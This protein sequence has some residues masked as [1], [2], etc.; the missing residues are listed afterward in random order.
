MYPHFNYKDIV[1]KNYIKRTGKIK[2]SRVEHGFK[3]LWQTNFEKI[4][5][6][7]FW[8]AQGPKWPQSHK[9]SC[10]EQIKWVE[11]RFQVAFVYLSK[12]VSENREK[13]IK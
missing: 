4:A 3:S 5:K 8:Y 7:V 12:H 9:T 11:A 6:T 10:K 1:I 2:L 13:H